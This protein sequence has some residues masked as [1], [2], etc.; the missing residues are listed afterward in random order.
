MLDTD[1]AYGLTISVDVGED[2][3]WRANAELLHQRMQSRGIAHRFELLPGEHAAEYWI[4]NVE[5][6]M[7]FY[8]SALAGTAKSSIGNDAH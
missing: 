1:T 3:P 2:D 6:Y 8:S 5:H 4:G 7:A